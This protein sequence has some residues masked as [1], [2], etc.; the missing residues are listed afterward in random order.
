MRHTCYR[1]WLYVGSGDSNS[2]PRACMAG[3]LHTDPHTFSRNRDY[4]DRRVPVSCK[5]SSHE[6]DLYSSVPLRSQASPCCP[7]LVVMQRC[8]A[9]AAGP[10]QLLLLLH[11]STQ[12][13]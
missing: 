4:R 5:H 3:A 2:G 1:S 10:F 8:S 11:V 13:G 12:L 7:L 6:S 9:S